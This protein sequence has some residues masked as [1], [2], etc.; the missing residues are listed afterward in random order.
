MYYTGYTMYVVDYMLSMHKTRTGC[1]LHV[2]GLYSSE[3]VSAIVARLPTEGRTVARFQHRY[4]I[5][6]DAYICVV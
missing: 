5:H 2:E 3:R 4:T 6:A 1:I